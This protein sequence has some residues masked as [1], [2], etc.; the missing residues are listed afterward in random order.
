MLFD[1]NRDNSLFV[2]SAKVENRWLVSFKSS[3]RS[4]RLPKG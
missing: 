3:L 1:I 4:D 2:F